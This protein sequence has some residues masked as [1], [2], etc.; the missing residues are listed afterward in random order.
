MG[1][2]WLQVW[3]EESEIKR[4][5]GSEECTLTTSRVAFQRESETGRETERGRHTLPELGSDR[6]RKR[7]RSGEREKEGES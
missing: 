4:E 2:F 5:G 1:P 3:R 6:A 7:E